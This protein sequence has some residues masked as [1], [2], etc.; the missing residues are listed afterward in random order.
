MRSLLLELKGKRMDRK[1]YDT[2]EGIRSL[3]TSLEGLHE[4]KRVRQAAG[5]KDKERL[6]EFL[7]LGTFY[8]DGCGNFGRSEVSLDDKVLGRKDFPD[9]VSSH[10]LFALKQMRVSTGYGPCLPPDH[11]ECDQCGRAWTLDDVEDCIGGETT[12]NREGMV[13][14]HR[15]CHRLRLA[16]DARDF[17]C[18]M[19]IEAGFKKNFLMNLIPNEYCKC[20][21]CKPWGLLSTL[22]GDIKIGWRKRVILISWEATGVQ[23]PYLFKEED[24]TQGGDYVHAWSRENGVAY[25]WRLKGAL[26][27]VKGFEL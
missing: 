3:L 7:I 15:R 12:K 20:E 1:I 21:R 22:A 2:E 9:V 27:V 6:D 25:L 16:R 5:Y 13:W 17:F 10:R 24:V 26:S 11:A 14:R 19:V 23:L 4:L 18:G 8:T